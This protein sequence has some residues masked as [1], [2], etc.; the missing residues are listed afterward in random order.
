MD[1]VYNT[2]SSMKD[3]GRNMMS[4]ILVQKW[5]RQTYLTD[6]KRKMGQRFETHTIFS[7]GEECKSGIADLPH[8]GHQH[9]FHGTNTH[10]TALTQPLAIAQ[11]PPKPKTHSTTPDTP[12]SVLC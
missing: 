5:L 6:G 9:T 3:M 2:L 8:L 10:S 7:S 12:M 4:G 11:T 1:R